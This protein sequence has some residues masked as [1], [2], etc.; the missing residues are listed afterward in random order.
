MKRVALAPALLLCCAPLAA[1]GGDVKGL[2]VQGNMNPIYMETAVVAVVNEAKIPLNSK[3]VCVEQA[4]G[5]SYACTGQVADGRKLTA[6]APY[7]KVNTSDNVNF[8]V[9]VGDRQ[10]YDGPIVPVLLKNAQV[11]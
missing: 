6:F 5:T 11:R 3:P 2:A 7:A 8:S 1:C 4:N 10:L 9:K